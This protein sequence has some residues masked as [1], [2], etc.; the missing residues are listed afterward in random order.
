M[1]TYAC[2]YVHAYRYLHVH[3]Y[4]LMLSRLGLGWWLIEMNTAFFIPQISNMGPKG[5]TESQSVR[6][7]SFVIEQVLLQF[8]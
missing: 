7:I 3:M 5:D 2:V 4:R 1:T 8:C 6:K